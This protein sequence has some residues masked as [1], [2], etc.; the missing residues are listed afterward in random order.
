[1]LSLEAVVINDDFYL[2]KHM[3]AAKSQMQKSGQL[4]MSAKG[5]RR[6]HNLPSLLQF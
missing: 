1:M 4:K 6:I 2:A 5:Y 3:K